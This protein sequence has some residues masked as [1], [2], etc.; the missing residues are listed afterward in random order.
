MESKYTF[1][2][3]ALLFFLSITLFSSTNSQDIISEHVKW[4]QY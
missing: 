1:F 4:I 2:K 3:Q